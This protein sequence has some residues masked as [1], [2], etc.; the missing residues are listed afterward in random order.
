M[1]IKNIV[2]LIICTLIQTSCNVHEPLYFNNTPVHSYLTANNFSQRDDSIFDMYINSQVIESS[3]FESYILSHSGLLSSDFYNVDK[4]TNGGWSAIK[5]KPKF[6]EI[7]NII[8]NSLKALDYKKNQNL[9]P[10]VSICIGY[11]DFKLDS[12]GMSVS[13]H[14]TINCSKYSVD[15]SHNRPLWKLNAHVVSNE[16]DIRAIIASMVKCATP[17]L[18]K[19]FKGTITCKR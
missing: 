13:K 2:F 12:Y 9:N 1:Y 19:N 4:Q 6:A 3:S 7:E 11:G 5:Q 14:L 8:H 15:F 17:Y 16:P 18:N 10:D